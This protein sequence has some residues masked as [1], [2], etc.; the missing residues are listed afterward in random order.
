MQANNMERKCSY[1]SIYKCR[2]EINKYLKNNGI[3]DF[4]NYRV[5]IKDD[6]LFFDYWG[7]FIEKPTIT[8][9][10]IPNIIYCQEMNQRILYF[11]LNM[12]S[13]PQHSNI[14]ARGI[15][16]S[17]N[18]NHEKIIGIT[19]IDIEITNFG[20]RPERDQILGPKLRL[21][22]GLLRTNSEIG[23]GDIT[24]TNFSGLIRILIYYTNS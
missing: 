22:H 17:N 14:N 6:E 7:Y 8:I 19:G 15:I 3:T 20:Y 18:V 12:G 24:I 23:K 10:N 13:I 21:H 9:Q 16:G 5:Y 1:Q 11:D 2:S 4:G